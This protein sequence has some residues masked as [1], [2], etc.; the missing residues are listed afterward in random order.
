MAN[1]FNKEERV[2]FENLLEGFNDALVLSRNV[3]IYNTDQTMMERTNNVIWRPQPY[4]ATSLSNAG[5]GTDITSVGGYASYTQLAVPASIN[6]TRTVAFELNAQE[7]R[8][9][10]Q[11]QRLGNSAKQKLASDINV[12]VLNIAANQGT[13]V[14]KR[15]AA[16]G[17]TS[18]FDDVAQCEAIFNEQGIM[19]GDRYLALN[20]RDYNGLANDL[21][22]AS[23][24]FGNQ[25][26]DKAYERAYVG[27]VASFDI[28]KLDY[29]VRL[30][31][32]SATATINTT[33]GGGNSYTPKAIS[34]SPTTS[35]R[36][37]VDNRFQ[38]LTVAVSAG[39]LAAG[40]AFTIAGIN[41]VH[42]ITKGDTGQPKTFRVISASAPAGGTQ[43]IV[44]SPPIISNQ[45]ANA[46]SAQN[47]N[48]VIVTAASNAAITLL[49]AVA[50]P[51]NCFW[52][53]D[54]IEILPG[55]YSLPDN[56][57]VAVMRGST[58]QGLEL[59]MTKR[60]DQNTLT[61]KYRVDTFY[62]VVNKQ[63]EMS[64]IIL[65][66]QGA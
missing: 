46:A 64:G 2:A 15:A 33:I 52:H 6:Q 49:N 66:N 45:V 26:S 3:S 32:G 17:A 14:V 11:E 47:Q 29:A 7:L 58:D 24:S 5:V 51:V 38:S 35:E 19:D 50:A 28:Y 30:A 41:A 12:S 59:V 4:I 22:K 63:P 16:A 42:H 20:T 8:D 34:T 21:A 23:R 57:G 18:G 25:K 60:F 31:A 53:K 37:N 65:F 55:R 36:L 9:A 48:C 39:A 27:M 44:I 10:L 43:A 61:T 13:L 1:S 56:A 54:A 62:G 40:D